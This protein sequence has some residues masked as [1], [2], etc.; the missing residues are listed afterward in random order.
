MRYR[1][2]KYNPARRNAAGVYLPDEWTSCTD[3]GKA[4]A[5]QKLTAEDYLPVESAYLEAIRI[6]A[7]AC[8][9]ASFRVRQ[10]ERLYSAWETS[11]KMKRLG[12]PLTEEELELYRRVE[13]SQTFDLQAALSLAKLILRE[14]LWATLYD[15]EGRL[16]FTFGYDYYLYADLPCL[17][18]E[19]IDRI[20]GL[21]LFVE[22][23][24]GETL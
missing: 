13:L 6:I 16:S 8:G 2:T 14:L 20:E 22:G 23:L 18:A 21:G 9:C 15:A 10:L 5:G 3:I 17:P 12:L 19:A 4:F 1:I 11:R 7:E 24:D